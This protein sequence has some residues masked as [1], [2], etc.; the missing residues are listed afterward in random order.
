[1][2]N[3]RLST[4]TMV[5]FGIGQTAETLRTVGSTTFLLFFYTQVVGLSGTLTA[6]ALSLS[7]IL[8]A[9]IDPLVGAL[10]DRTRSRW[11]R[12]HPFM[13]A[14]ML[15]LPVLFYATFNPPALSSGGYFAWLLGTTLLTR[16]ALSV[17]H[18]P[19]TALAAEMARDYTQR[20]TVFA[21][22]TF[23]G[24]LA[25]SAAPGIALRFFFPT[26]EQFNP[27][28]LNVDGYR[29]FSLA[30]G[31]AMFVSIGISIAGT[32]REIPHLTQ[33]PTRDAFSVLRAFKDI[34]QVFHNHSFRV[35][36]FGF[37]L[38]SLMLAAESVLW[39]Y[40]Q[41][42]FWELTTEQMS[43]FSL[44]AFAGLACGMPLVPIVTRWLDKKKTLVLSCLV[45]IGLVHAPIVLRLLDPP[46]FPKNGSPVILPMLLCCSFATL[47]LSPLIYATL[48]SMFADIADEHELETG[49]R[50]EGI[51]FASRSLALQLIQSAGVTLGGVL[52][53]LITFPKGARAG[54]V[55]AEV[56]W[57]LGLMPVAAAAINACGVLLYTRYRLNRRRHAEIVSELAARRASLTASPR[58]PEPVTALSAPAE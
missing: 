3:R 33:Q 39:P 11:G 50:R 31:L 1:M 58:G 38:A 40:M 8:D 10:S 32:W 56:L 16:I 15:P 34:V 51:I 48:S 46:W 25:F 9:L 43:L 22:H 45:S 49:E 54:T 12:R 20:S 17:F 44:V 2:S 7:L 26:T 30:Y 27:G 37:L 53:D 18:V 21:Y 19:Y 47:L 41:P 29:G 36:F 55:P 28:L 42:Y 13:I 4:G 6:L 35:L 57:N 5:A 23:F 14:G 52:L 24:M